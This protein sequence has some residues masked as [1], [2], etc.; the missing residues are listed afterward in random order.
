MTPFLPLQTVKHHNLTVTILKKYSALTVLRADVFLGKMM[1]DDAQPVVEADFLVSERLLQLMEIETP[2]RVALKEF[3][4][5]DTVV[6]GIGS[7]RFLV[8][9]FSRHALDRLA[10]SA[11]A[12]H[13]DF[14]FP[15]AEFNCPLS[16]TESIAGMISA[17][18]N[19]YRTPTAKS[20]LIDTFSYYF[21][22]LF[23][24]AKEIL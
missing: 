18:Y 20:I 24:L 16:N 4:E 7:E 2:V 21:I 23:V 13:L 9:H 17:S 22:Q 11:Y 6:T 5:S 1:H 19:D 8:V 10:A 15:R 12:P 3:F 14:D